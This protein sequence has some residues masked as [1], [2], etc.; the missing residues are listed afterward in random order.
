[1]SVSPFF[2]REGEELRDRPGRRKLREFP[3]GRAPGQSCARVT[4]ETVGRRIRRL[5][6]ERGLS[7]RDLSEPG[8]SY[9]YISRVEA[10]VRNPSEKALRAFGGR[11]APAKRPRLPPVFDPLS[12]RLYS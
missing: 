12:G 3:R 9:A 11:R 4:V 7:Q 8:T 2:G 5:R 6:E 1:M 10:G